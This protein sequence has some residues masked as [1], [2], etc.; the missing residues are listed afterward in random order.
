MQERVDDGEFDGVWMAHR[1]DEPLRDAFSNGWDD[2]GGDA[3]D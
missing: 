1:T 2:A 3:L